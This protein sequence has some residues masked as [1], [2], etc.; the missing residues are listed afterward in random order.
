VSQKGT[1]DSIDPALIDQL[2]DLVISKLEER[3]RST[4]TF[5]QGVAGSNPARL[6][7]FSGFE[8]LTGNSKCRGGT[9]IEAGHR[10][11]SACKI[12]KLLCVL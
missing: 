2:C 10:Q 7:S 12:R 1:P 4:L 11:V 8:L 9:I 5:N 6:T 3:A